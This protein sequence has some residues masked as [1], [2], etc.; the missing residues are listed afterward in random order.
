MEAHTGIVGVGGGGGGGGGGGEGGRKSLRLQLAM[1]E[2]PPTRLELFGWYVYGMCSYFV[3]CFLLPI[4]FPLIVAQRATRHSELLQH[5]PAA[6]FAG[7]AC[8]HKDWTLYQMVVE[9]SIAVGS[10]SLSPLH[11]TA[12]SWFIGIVLAAPMLPYLARQLDRGHQQLI[13]ATSTVAG[14]FCCLLTGFFK[15]TWVFPF[16]IIAVTIAI[17]MASAAH[18]RQFGLILQG[19]AAAKTHQRFLVSSRLSMYVTAAGNLGTA[20]IA[21]F[22]Y[23]MLRRADHLTSLWV[24]SIFAG[25]KWSLGIANTFTNRPESQQ[26]SSPRLIS[27]Y[28]PQVIGGL[29]GVFLS[30]FSSTCL[31]TATTL[32]VVGGLCIKP[33]LVLTLWFI[34]FAFAAVSLPLLH[35]VQL[36]IRADAAKMNL[37]GFMLSAFSA[38]CGFYFKDQHWKWSHIFLVTL[39]QSTSVGILHAFGRVM[40]LDRSPIGKEAVLSTLFEWVKISGAFAGFAVVAVFPRNIKA[41]YGVSF[42]AVFVGII[43]LI[44]GNS[45]GYLGRDSSERRGE[46][47]I[48]GAPMIG[49]DKEGRDCVGSGQKMDSEKAERNRLDLH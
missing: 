26:L 31:F 41:T 8:S 4:L 43:V 34:Y 42:L 12:I 17:T 9:R 21:A 28:C 16:Y 48:D 23:Q 35:P 10:S 6:T 2:E 32:Y 45:A 20:I 37:L 18:T 19:L 29:I 5:Q 24:V 36:L 30:S 11:W 1:L 15:T 13:L 49:L 22:T 39:M 33:V 40:I 14:A 46:A 27:D 38:G 25:L 7:V 3:Q 47:R 44:F